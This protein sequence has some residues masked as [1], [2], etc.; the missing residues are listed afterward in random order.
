MRRRQF[1][2]SRCIQLLK[3]LLIPSDLGR[4]VAILHQMS[5]MLGE[6]VLVLIWL[7]G[8]TTINCKDLCFQSPITQYSLTYAEQT[9][10]SRQIR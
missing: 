9:S 6:M 8:Q 2:L 7:N 3:L 5:S 10:K 1:M 4:F